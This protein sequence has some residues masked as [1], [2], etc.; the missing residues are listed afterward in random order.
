LRISRLGRKPPG[1]GPGREAPPLRVLHC[2]TNIGGHPAGLAAAERELG[3]ASRAVVFR[4][5][6]FGFP[7]DEVLAE[8]GVSPLHFE[9]R[10]WKLLVAA[11]L[12][13]D[14]VH[15]NFG[16]TILPS[17][18]SLATLSE[19]G[20]PAAVRA[21]Y[22]AYAKALEFRDLPLL[23]AAGRVLAVTFQGDD[24]RQGDVC[25]ALY[26]IEPSREAGYYSAESDAAARRRIRSFDR[27]ADLIYTV[28]PDLLRVLPARARFLP[29]AHVDPRR[30]AEV[31]VSRE[32]A[33]PLLVHA[34][35]DRGVKGTRFVLAAVERLRAAG[36]KFRFRLVEGLS[37][38]EARKVYEAADLVVDQLLVGWYG[39]LAVEAMALGKPVIAY[40]RDEDLGRLPPGMA[41]ELP[42]LRATPDRI[43]GVLRRWLTA[44]ADELRAAGR[45]S[46][47]FT[48]RWH[49][50]RRIAAEVVRDYAE[51]LGRRGKLARSAR[52]LPRG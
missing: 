38:E 7:A 41:A 36:V 6:P 32:A 33:P 42:I 1:A 46:R 29:Y 15:F 13:H 50:P 17:P 19:Q 12:A 9:L 4:R 10:R 45:A 16:R 43:E 27:H 30:W 11:L 51:A 44:P 21:A 34:P 26:E 49:D 37:H 8:D 18:I 3:V 28:N 23:R 47:R 5:S 25:R 39:G 22:T 31:G 2:P 52:E 48:E 14:V 35:T 24:A 40:L 20:Y